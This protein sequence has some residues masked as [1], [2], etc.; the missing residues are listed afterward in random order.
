MNCSASPRRESADL[1]ACSRHLPCSNGRVPCRQ[2]SL[3]RCRSSHSR[4]PSV[5]CDNSHQTRPQ[6]HSSRFK[7]QLL[8]LAA[9]GVTTLAAGTVRYSLIRAGVSLLCSTFLPICQ[10]CY[11]T[12]VRICAC[13]QQ[14]RRIFCKWFH[15][16]RQCGGSGSGGS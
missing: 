15:L 2:P 3:V 13:Y 7:R 8:S 14:D 16:Q 1:C 6:L 9:A 12:Y 10:P 5:S 11:A 4:R